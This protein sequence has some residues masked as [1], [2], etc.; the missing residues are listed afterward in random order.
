MLHLVP[1]GYNTLSNM[2]DLPQIAL[3]A[4]EVVHKDLPL[5]LYT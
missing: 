3:V 1:K 5:C 4:V 2:Y